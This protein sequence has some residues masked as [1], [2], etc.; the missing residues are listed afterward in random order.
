MPKQMVCNV[1]KLPGSNASLLDAL[2]F[3]TQKHNNEHF[4]S[5]FLE[6]DNNPHSALSAE[7]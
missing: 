2:K 7:I 6:Q 4:L 3:L 1:L 5:K